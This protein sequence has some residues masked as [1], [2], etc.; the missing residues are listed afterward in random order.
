MLFRNSMVF[1]V[2]RVTA[3]LFSLATTALLTRVL[4][5]GVYGV[6][7]LAL[8]VMSFTCSIAFT[9]LNLAYTRFA[10]TPRDWPK[11]S[12]T[13]VLLFAVLIALTG[14][15]TLALV[16]TG[17][18]KSLAPP[19][20]VGMALAWAMAWFE[21]CAVYETNV[22]RPL[23][24]LKMNV[25]RAALGLGFALGAAAAT[26]DPMLT[27]LGTAAGM[28]AGS[29]ASRF[30]GAPV[31]LANFD[32]ALAAQLVQFGWPFALTMAMEAILLGA[33]RFLLEGLHSSA[34]LGQFTVAFLL[35]QN[36]ITLVGGGISSAGYSLALRRAEDGGMDALRR[37]LLSTGELLL[38]VSAPLALGIGLTASGLADTLVG[39]KYGPDLQVLTP[40]VAAGGLA[41]AWR[42]SFFDQ[43]FQ[44]RKKVYIQT[45]ISG[46]AAVVSIALSVVLVPSNGALGAA[47][48]VAVAN[49][50]ACA[51]SFLFGRVVFPM[52]LP[53]GA[54][55]RVLA[56]CLVMTGLVL[57]VP[58][59]SPWSFAG[60]VAFGAL[61]Y[62]LAAF[63]FNLL[64]VRESALALLARGV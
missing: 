26:H 2:G 41:S 64:S 34:A 12:S 28:I 50:C 21:L 33:P 55:A 54:G 16:A 36:T 6:Y 15:A 62:A 11:T 22:F 47:I 8:V 52:P 39:A 31:K 42:A 20:L 4:D 18:L 27:G 9:W 19:I 51:L 25:W 45:C 44:I 7:A 10:Q 35:V 17:S 59:E 53:L 37:Q 1:M 29:F 56:C 57:I 32:R 24:Y 46:L 5:P 60:K 14:A 58:A 40:W 13:I 61:G 3:G 49:V 38:A 23:S 63:A 43:A 30:P 48:A